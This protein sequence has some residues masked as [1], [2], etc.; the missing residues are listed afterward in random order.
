VALERVYGTYG[1]LT[2]FYPGGRTIEAILFD[3]MTNAQ[4]KPEYIFAGRRL[5]YAE[6]I[7]AF[8]AKLKNGHSIEACNGGL[9]LVGALSK[10]RNV[11]LGLVTGNHYKTAVLKLTTAGFDFKC[12]EVGAYGHESADRSQLV[13]LARERAVKQVGSEIASQDIVVI[14]DTA[15]DIEA[16]KGAGV[17]NIAVAT[18]TDEIEMLREA[19]PDFLFED[20]ANT[21]SVLDAILD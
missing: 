7:A 2:E 6:Y 15:R 16:A 9:E 17:R 5:F 3:T 11:L 13:E 10:A 1:N 8:T 19:Q 18:G 20:F 21:Q 12:F 14:G 4:I